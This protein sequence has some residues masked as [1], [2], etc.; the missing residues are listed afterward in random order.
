MADEK[1][2][3]AAKVSPDPTLLSEPAAQLGFVGHARIQRR[4][5]GC[6]ISG[7]GAPAEAMPRP[8]M[9]ASALPGSGAL[10]GT[11]RCR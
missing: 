9:P 6:L 8:R 5:G 2:T 11:S 10:P 1:R 7:V 4:D 3:L